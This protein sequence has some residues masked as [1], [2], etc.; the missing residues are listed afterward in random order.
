MKKIIQGNTVSNLK[1]YTFLFIQT[2]INNN[3]KARHR[4]HKREGIKRRVTGKYA[5]VNKVY[6]EKYTDIKTKGHNVMHSFKHTDA[7]QFA[8]QAKEYK[9]Q[10]KA[11]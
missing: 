2:C 6:R 10:G 1:T 4:E 5:N 11:N 9:E 3:I 7:K 8:F